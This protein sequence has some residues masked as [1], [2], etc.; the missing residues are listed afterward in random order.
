MVLSWRNHEAARE[1][2]KSKIAINEIQHENWFK[3]RL[4]LLDSQPF[5][6]FTYE[7][8]EIGYVRFDKSN[9]YENSLEISICVNPDFY[10][11]GHG[12]SILDQ[13]LSLI[14]TKFP[15]VRLIAT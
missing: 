3:S 6:I 9:E 8:D 12:Q 2:S 10:T 15:L 13:S 5:W 4:K 7:S 1:F 14:F 11:K